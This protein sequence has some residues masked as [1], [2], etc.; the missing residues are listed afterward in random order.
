MR[1][2]SFEKHKRHKIGWSFWGDYRCRESLETCTKKSRHVIWK[3]KTKKMS[4]L[5]EQSTPK[6]SQPATT[7]LQSCSQ[8]YRWQKSSSHGEKRRR[9]LVKD[10]K[11][12]SVWL[13]RED[14]SGILSS[15]QMSINKGKPMQNRNIWWIETD[16]LECLKNEVS[17]W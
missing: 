1:N 14:E 3:Q 17:S 15:T 6:R 10:D 16:L 11:D 2:S 9:K 5:N 13:R 12:E 7:N 8:Y 4:M